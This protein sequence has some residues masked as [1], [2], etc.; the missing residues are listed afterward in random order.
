MHPSQPSNIMIKIQWPLTPSM[1]DDDPMC[2]WLEDLVKRSPK[3]SIFELNASRTEI[4]FFKEEDAIAF[5]L[6]FGL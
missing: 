4:H 3:E 5:R 1:S 6:K 2:D